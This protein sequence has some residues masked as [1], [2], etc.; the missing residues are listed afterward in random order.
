MSIN[1]SIVTTG[2]DDNYGGN[3]L[4]RL[5]KSLQVNCDLLNALNIKYEYI[6]VEWHPIREVLY[7]N[8]KTAHVFQNERYPIVSVLVDPSIVKAEGLDVT[9]YYEY[10][11]KNVGIRHAQGK[12]LLILNSDILLTA[13][14]AQH[15]Q[16][17]IHDNQITDQQFYRAQFR[18]R[19]HIN[20]DTP[21]SQTDL[22]AI[23]DD[24]KAICS[25]YSG[26]FLLGSKTA[27]VD[28]GRGYNETDPAHR[29]TYQTSMDG[30]ILWNMHKQGLEMQLLKEPY[31]HIEHG[32]PHQYDNHYN[33]SRYTN[34]S[35]W[36]FTSYP[37]SEVVPNKVYK[38]SL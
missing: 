27:I 18:E 16:Q 29:I 21:F 15:I 22:L 26:D 33:R 9:K 28:F 14:L 24:E 30:E 8:K 1:L 5:L 2:R 36:G 19:I 34:K 10:F 20:Q 3:F 23:S 32:K 37:K 6:V 11:A 13:G 4:E 12:H 25:P 31:Q 17:L 38:I 35:D 7:H